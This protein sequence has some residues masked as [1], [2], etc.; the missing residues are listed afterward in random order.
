MH[1]TEMQVCVTGLKVTVSPV[2]IASGTNVVRVCVPCSCLGT[3][4]LDTLSNMAFNVMFR[5]I[6]RG[7]VR[8]DL[9]LFPFEV[10]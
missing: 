1:K 7:K 9:C 2:I 6:A 8:N 10:C 5:S 4:R 3:L